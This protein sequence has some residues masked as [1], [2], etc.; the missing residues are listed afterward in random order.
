MR[1][2]IHII[3]RRNFIGPMDIILQSIE[4]PILMDTDTIFIMELM[5]TMKTQKMLNRINCYIIS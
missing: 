2:C 1:Y 3:D 5:G 4:N